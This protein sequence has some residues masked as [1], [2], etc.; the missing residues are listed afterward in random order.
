MKAEDSQTTLKQEDLASE[1]PALWGLDL[2]A[3]RSPN[4]PLVAG[5]QAAS[6]SGLPVFGAE[7]ARA[8]LLKAFA[9]S[10]SSTEEPSPKKKTAAAIKVEKEYN[11]ALLLQALGILFTS[12]AHVLKRDE[13]DRRAW[14]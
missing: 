10:P 3:L 9:S 11:L 6:S 12:W 13:L 4:G 1:E 14:G 5:A 8:H 7:H 2:E